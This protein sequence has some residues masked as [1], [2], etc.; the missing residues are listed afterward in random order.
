M[1][2]ITIRIAAC[3]DI[4][5]PP[6]RVFALISDA[7][8][9]A[10]LNRS[11]QVIRIER[12]TPGPLGV[13]SVTFYRMQ[14]GTRIFEYCMRCTHFEPD[15]LIESRAELPILFTVR[16][17]VEQTPTGS[18]LKQSEQCEASPEMLE[19]LPATPRA[20]RAWRFIK[21]LHFVVPEMAQGT[22]EVIAR[23][24]A[25]S[26]RFRMQRELETW[27]QAIKEHIESREPSAR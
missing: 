15:R 17:E 13:G 2:A 1:D 27:L 25:D 9:K 12:E 16:L 11:V 7:E 14:H 21:L 20:E 4:G 6:A 5:A 19:G 22:W 24:R 10:R 26:L 23:E 3:V 18:R 8:A